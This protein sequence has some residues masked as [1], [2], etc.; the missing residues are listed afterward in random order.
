MV[1]DFLRGQWRANQLQN[2]SL[3]FGRSKAARVGFS[4]VSDPKSGSKSETNNRKS[5][6]VQAETKKAT[7]TSRTSS[8]KLHKQQHKQKQQQHSSTNNRVNSKMFWKVKQKRAK[9]GVSTVGDLKAPAAAAAATKQQR[10][11]QKNRNQQQQKQHH[12][13]Q[14]QHQTAAKNGKNNTKKQ[15]KQCKH[16]GRSKVARVGFSGATN[17]GHDRLWPTAFP[18]LATTY[19][20]H[21]LLWPRPSLAT[22]SFGLRG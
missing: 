17:F 10:Q 21:D 11:Q 22:I 2:C 14:Q 19:F 6:T 1:I 15:Q 12:K 3:H 16:F 13:Q 18:T 20:G 5:V 8:S 7:T 4:T 9:I